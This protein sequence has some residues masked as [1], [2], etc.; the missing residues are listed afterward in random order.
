MIFCKH[1]FFMH[2]LLLSCT[3]VVAAC[4]GGTESVT[5]APSPVPTPVSP[6]PPAEMRILMLGQSISSNCNEHIY[7][8]VENVFQIDK[9][10]ELVAAKDPFIWAD[11][12]KGSMWMPLGK[13]MIDSGLVPKVVFMP[14]GVDS[15]RVQ[16]WQDGGAAFA[17]LNTVIALAR[18]KNL[19]FDYV[20]WHQGSADIGMNRDEYLSRLTAVANYVNSNLQVGAWIVALHSRCFGRYDEGIEWAQKTFGDSPANR[21]Y[22]GPNNNLLG[23]EYRFD[24]CHLNQKGQEEM[25]SLWFAA[26][27]KSLGK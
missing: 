14:I 6:A 5:T 10:G 23:D 4:S 13:Q 9:V 2:V 8:P 1:R 19:K 17:K 7:G 18:Q 21:R 22:L 24:S 16:D 12:S 26:I 27:K 15:S 3:I 11:C 25:A 20:F